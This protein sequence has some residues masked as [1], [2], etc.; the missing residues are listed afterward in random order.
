[1]GQQRPV[2]G[3]AMGPKQFRQAN[4]APIQSPLMPPQP[5]D[6]AQELAEAIYAE[7][8]ASHIAGH[9][10]VETFKT[11][12]KHAQTAAKAFYEVDRPQSDVLS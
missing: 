11:M 9:A 5:A 4:A 1:M 10:D 3:I 8:A 7:A 6:R 12:A 2:P